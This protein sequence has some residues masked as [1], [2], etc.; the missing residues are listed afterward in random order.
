MMSSSPIFARRVVGGLFARPSG[1]GA[2]L[3]IDVLAARLVVDLTDGDELAAAIAEG[4][5]RNGIPVVRPALGAAAVVLQHMSSKWRLATLRQM[6]DFVARALGDNQFRSAIE[7]D[8]TA[9]LIALTANGSGWNWLSQDLQ[10]SR[11]DAD[12]SAADVLFA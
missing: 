7:T 3:P 2:T 10:T 4:A 1:R 11:R 9:N 6:L 12:R 8:T 5:Q